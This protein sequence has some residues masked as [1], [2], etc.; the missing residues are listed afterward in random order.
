MEN[1]IKI[2]IV[3]MLI[4]IVYRR[5]CNKIEGMADT[6]NITEQINKIYK[7]DIQ[8]IRNLEA[9][10]QKLQHGGLTVAGD[11]TVDGK[12]NYLPKGTIVAYNGTKAPKGWALCNG[13]NGTPDLRGRFIRMFNDNIGGFNGWGGK[14][15]GGNKTSYSADIG[16]NSRADKNSWMLKHKFG[17]KA[18]TDH[19]VL[20][21]NELPAHNHTGTTS[22][23]G[24]HQHG[25]NIY[26]NNTCSGTGCSGRWRIGDYGRANTDW[27][28][29]HNHNFTTNSTG[30][31][32]GHNN[33][34]PYYVLS[35]IMKL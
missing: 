9:I 30:S 31:N 11:L 32:W 4:F 5:L 23:N 15:I 25:Y 10:S 17:D 14:V 20:S 16:G 35:Y 8:S 27:N 2:V 1:S 22:T 28:G 24:N 13:Q 6:T 26:H 18:G 29:N 34:P 7:A 12:F 3:L 33:Q 19:Q 21:V